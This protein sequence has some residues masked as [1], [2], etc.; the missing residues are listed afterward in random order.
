MIRKTE[1]IKETIRNF[2]E[3]RIYDEVFKMKCVLDDIDIR[4]AI[5]EGNINEHKAI[6]IGY[7]KCR[8]ER[9]KRNPWKNNVSYWFDSMK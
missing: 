9:G 2:W 4:I 5:A 7:P 6:A 8:I 3:V 1:D